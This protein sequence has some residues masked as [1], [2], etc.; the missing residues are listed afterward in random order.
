VSSSRWR[1]FTTWLN[2]E[3]ALRAAAWAV[4]VPAL[5]LAL[6]ALLIPLGLSAE[7]DAVDYRIPL[8]QWMLRHGAYPNWPWSMVDDYPLLGEV[9]MVP[10]YWLHPALARLVP[11]AGYFGLA[12]FAGK[13]A[14]FFARGKLPLQGS[15]VVLVTMAWVLAF[16]PIT[17]QSNLLMIDNLVA[18]FLLGSLYFVLLRRAGPAGLLAACAL[19][20]RY[21]VW[22]TVALFP[23]FLWWLSE[24]DRRWRNCFKF[25]LIASLGALPFLVRNFLVNDGN[26]VFPIGTAVYASMNMGSYG[27]G[28]DWLSFLLLPWDLLYTHP[29]RTGFYDYGYSRH[30][31]QQL[32]ALPVVLLLAPKLVAVPLFRRKEGAVLL[33]YAFLQ[34]FIWFKTSQQMRF[35]VP[36]FVILLIWM[37]LVFLK[38][39]WRWMAVVLTI[40]GLFSVESYQRNTWKMAFFGRESNFAWAVRKAEDCFQRAGVGEKDVVGYVDREAV[41]GFLSQEFVF[42]EEHVYGV[43]V[44]GM[45]MPP[46]IFSVRPLTVRSGYEPWP[47]EEPC[48]LRRVSSAI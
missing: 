16:R 4:V 46:W 42:L 10:F 29:F 2:S 18:A 6:P 36:A 24:S 12:Y 43:P 38:S 26:P 17:I 40:L 9:L 28:S 48:L 30:F 23:L 21:T 47:A 32:L 5:V 11:L 8:V 44:P 33:A 3:G 45:E 39:R 15:T 34:L 13:I 14:E 31:F 7:E 19:A 25:C 37:L 22:A 35:L 27:R 1:S 41:L 20:T